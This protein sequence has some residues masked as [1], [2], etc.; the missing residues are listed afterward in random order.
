MET[1]ERSDLINEILTAPFSFLKTLRPGSAV[2]QA[3]KEAVWREVERLFSAEKP[4]AV[5]CGPFG[6]IRVPF[7]NMGAVTSRHLLEL[8]CLVEFNL[9]RAN[10][11]RYQNYLDL[12]ANIGVHTLMARRCGYTVRSFEP[13]PIHC[14]QLRRLMELN[15]DGGPP[16]DIRQAAVSDTAG[17]ASFCRVKGNTTSSHLAGAKANPYGEL[18]HLE[19]A[20]EAAL[21]HLEWADFVKMDVEGMEA[22][23]LRAT[24][25]RLWETTDALVE[26]GTAENAADIFDHFQNLGVNIFAQK[27]GW[28]KAAALRDLPV[29]YKEGV[30][31]ISTADRVPW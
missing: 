4:A 11:E 5:D 1:P 6:L 22:T 28:E 16:P 10:R 18:E 14:D 17:R 27:I 9:F 19:V 24:G 26:I 8:D 20:V 3:L 30:V 29:N 12:G 21:P 13:D 25:R 31:I 23:I 7:F 15:P 2:Y